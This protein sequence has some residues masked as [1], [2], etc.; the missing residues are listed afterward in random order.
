MASYYTLELSVAP[1]TAR[2]YSVWAL[3]T[4]DEV[5]ATFLRD[6]Q[7]T[8]FACYYGERMLARVH[9][10]G[11]T[12]FALDL[13]PFV[14]FTIKPQFATRLP[15]R[16][17]FTKI[18]A[19]DWEAMDDQ[20]REDLD[21]VIDAEDDEEQEGPYTV[22]LRSSR[23]SFLTLLQVVLDTEALLAALPPLPTPLAQGSVVFAD[24]IGY[25]GRIEMGSVVELDE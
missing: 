23:R 22:S 13:H 11:I 17:T 12:Q 7:T 19:D 1:G 5:V 2:R 9:T 4:A 14:S 24:E 6:L 21:D 10:D 18:A 15:A 3:A 20:G 16:L 25:V 8:W